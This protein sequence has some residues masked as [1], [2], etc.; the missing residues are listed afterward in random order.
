MWFAQ[1][2]VSVS[3]GGAYGVDLFFALSAYLITELLLREREE[4]GSLDIRSFY[5]RRIL[6]IWPLYYLFIA[7]CVV[8]PFL[9]PLRAFGFHYVVG[10]IF[11]AGNWSTIAFGPPEFAGLP[12]WSVSAEEQFY[13]LWPLIIRRLSRRGIGVAAVLMIV[14]ANLTRLAVL[15]QHGIG[16]SVWANTFARLDPMAIG[17]LIALFLRGRTLDFGLPLRASL[18]GAGILG[19]IA[20]GHFAAPWGDGL[21]WAGTLISYPVIALCSGALLFGTIGIGLRLRP[22]EYLG[23]ISYGLYVYHQMCIWITDRVLHV[24][25]GVFHMCLREGVALGITILVS[26]V[27]Y[28][29]LEKPFLNLKRRFT[30]VG[31]RPV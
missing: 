2:Q 20:T 30:Y 23:K 3:R 4:Q 13:L 21:P 19:I 15:L 22:I 24:R 14:V 1:L 16:W 26:S 27:S 28:A 6:R 25:N 8:V 17:I 11:L 5:V 18:L 29:V 7:A 9:N 31:S 10:F 12:L